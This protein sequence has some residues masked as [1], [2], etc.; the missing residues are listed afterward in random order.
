MSNHLNAPQVFLVGSP[1]S[2]TTALAG[3]MLA[4]KYNGFYEGN[5][6]GIIERIDNIVNQY[7]AV[8]G[9]NNPLVLTSRLSNEEVKMEIHLLL[10]RLFE[11]ENPKTPW[12]DKSGNLIT[13]IP[14]ILKLWPNAHFIFAKRRAIENIL[15]RIKKF[16]NHSFEFHCR[17]WAAIMASWRNVREI[18]PGLKA[19]EV[20]QQ[21]M[22]QTPDETAVRV[23]SFLSLA[24]EQRESFAK[25]LGNRRPERT[26]PGTEQ[27]ISSFEHVPW[28][29]EQRATFLHH[30]SVEMEA[31]GYTMDCTYRKNR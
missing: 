19:I 18:V 1:R 22:I 10:K 24:P 11:R 29:E 27:I 20:D 21:D 5:F 3:A 30:C 2:G 14:A 26:S 13:S 6:L 31:F 17:D 15:S 8:F 7:F 4:A 12:F 16:P 28:S 23:A 25:F 9:S